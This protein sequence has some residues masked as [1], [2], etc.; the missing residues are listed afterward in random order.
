MASLWLLILKR[1][2]CVC[3]CK[4]SKTPLPSMPVFQLG[5]CLPRCSK[6]RYLKGSFSFQPWQPHPESSVQSSQYSRLGAERRTEQN[7]GQYTFKPKHDPTKL[8]QTKPYFKSNMPPL[9]LR[10]LFMRDRIQLYELS[11]NPL[12]RTFYKVLHSIYYTRPQVSIRYLLL[13]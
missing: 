1:K 10:N 7:T 5:G 8:L 3:V 9:F 13:L 6:A 2:F 11:L 12:C 4:I